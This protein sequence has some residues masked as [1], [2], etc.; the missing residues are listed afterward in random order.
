MGRLRRG[1][2]IGILL[3]LVALAAPALA[4]ER[5]APARVDLF[6]T[7]SNRTGSAVINERTQRI[8]L[9]DMKSNR[10]GYG[11][12]DK[13]GRVDLFDTKSRRTGSG[14]ITPG[15]PRSNGGRP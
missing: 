11:T 7:Q 2:S 3:G 6:D 4:E 8:D 1:L 13:N 15:S 12:I 14:Q 10:T 9:Y 5:S